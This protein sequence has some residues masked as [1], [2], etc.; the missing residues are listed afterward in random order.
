MSIFIA[1]ETYFSLFRVF[2]CFIVFLCLW[3]CL[4]LDVYKRQ[5]LDVARIDDV[6]GTIAGD[7]TVLIICTSDQGA[8]NAQEYLTSLA[9]GGSHQSVL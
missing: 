6:V 3:F 8:L 4:V 1:I 7:D 2:L 5:A 9:G